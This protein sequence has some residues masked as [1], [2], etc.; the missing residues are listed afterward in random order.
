MREKYDLPQPDP[1]T[2][3]RHAQR[4]EPGGRTEGLRVNAQR[5]LEAATE[6]QDQ[7]KAESKKPF[8]QRLN[9]FR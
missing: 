1:L 4:G 7:R 2:P 8:W 5:F 9:P 6:L 3:S